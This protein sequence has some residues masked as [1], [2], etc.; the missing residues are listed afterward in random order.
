MYLDI[1]LYSL[2]G[3]HVLH[4][5]SLTVCN[6]TRTGQEYLHG[7]FGRLSGR[8]GE[9][10]SSMQEGERDSEQSGQEASAHSH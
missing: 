5:E 10:L 3:F 8:M 1:L 9:V 4:N 6:V 2:G 7:T